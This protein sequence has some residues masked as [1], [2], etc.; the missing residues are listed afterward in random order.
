MVD[1][2]SNSL[3]SQDQT[4]LLVSQMSLIQESH[5]SSF[6]EEHSAG[7]PFG[8]HLKN[9][10]ESLKHEIKEFYLFLRDKSR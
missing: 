4:C 2:S 10:L 9:E 8:K 7:E 3:T 6:K 1:L 5:V